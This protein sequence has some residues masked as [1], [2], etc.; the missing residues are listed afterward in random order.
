MHESPY[1][2]HYGIWYRRCGDCANGPASERNF[3]CTHPEDDIF[4]CLYGQ[5][6]RRGATCGTRRALTANGHIG[7]QGRTY[8]PITP[9]IPQ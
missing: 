7:A 5:H 3:H 6:A 9:H 1:A 4:G 8:K 2:N